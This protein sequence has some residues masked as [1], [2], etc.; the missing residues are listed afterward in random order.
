MCMCWVPARKSATDGG[1]QIAWHQSGCVGR[2]TKHHIRSSVRQYFVFI[3]LIVWYRKPLWISMRGSFKWTIS[4]TNI[5]PLVLHNDFSH[6]NPSVLCKHVFFWNLVRIWFSIFNLNYRLFI[7]NIDMFFC[8]KE[9]LKN[10]NLISKKGQK[11]NIK[12]SSK[13]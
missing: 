9:S 7:K 8:S 6:M 4:W 13:V 11:C 5:G 3:L 12:F 1:L 2:L 10:K